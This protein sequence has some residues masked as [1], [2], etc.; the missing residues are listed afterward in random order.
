MSSILSINLRGMGDPSKRYRLRDILNS[1]KP[2]MVLAQET[3]CD[4]MKEIQNI[5][6]IR[7]RW[8]AVAVDAIGHSRGMLACWDRSRVNVLAYRFLGGILLSGYICGILEKV[9]II[10]IYAPS[11]GRYEF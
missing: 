9:N 5:L 11:R 8:H 3:L 10:N 1:M 2:I 4:R 7:P 6:S